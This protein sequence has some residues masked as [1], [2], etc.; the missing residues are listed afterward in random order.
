MIFQWIPSHIRILGYEKANLAAKNR[1]E[2]G[3]KLIERWSLM[4]YIKKNVD[5]IRSKAI[6]QWDET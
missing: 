2:K 3:R 6:A 1:S 4:A 5:K